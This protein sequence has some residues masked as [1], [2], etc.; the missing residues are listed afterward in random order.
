[1]PEK[2]KMKVFGHVTL[3]PQ[4]PLAMERENAFL[5]NNGIDLSKTSMETLDRLSRAIEVK[6][7]QG[8]MGALFRALAEQ[9]PK[10]ALMIEISS[11]EKK[12]FEVAAPIKR[13]ALEMAG[14]TVFSGLNPEQRNLSADQ[15]AA[16]YLKSMACIPKKQVEPSERVKNMNREN[17]RRYLKAYAAN[18]EMPRLTD[19]I[20]MQSKRIEKQAFPTGI[21]TWKPEELEKLQR[22]MNND[23]SLKRMRAAHVSMDKVRTTVLQEAGVNLDQLSLFLGNKA[24]AGSAVI[25]APLI[26]S[27]LAS[28]DPV[29]QDIVKMYGG[30]DA[31]RKIIERDVKTYL[32][33]GGSI[34]N[35]KEAFPDTESFNAWKALYS[36]HFKG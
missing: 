1:M 27:S 19:Q 29:L 21:K 33:A 28:N 32:S 13:R 23:P 18:K 7:R 3:V 14:N 24:I 36:R 17:L 31:L 25:I 20:T 34:G 30:P 22:A 9:N 15:S 26:M 35:L 11:Y 4:I 10:K 8:V 16:D 6:D 5:K 12:G 2:I